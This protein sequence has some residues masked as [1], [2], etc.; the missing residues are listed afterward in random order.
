METQV[1]KPTCI[2]QAL[3]PQTGCLLVEILLA[4]ARLS[5]GASQSLSPRERLAQV[6]LKGN[7][8]PQGHMVSHSLNVQTR[9]ICFVFCFWSFFILCTICYSTTCISKRWQ[10]KQQYQINRPMIPSQ[11]QPIHKYFWRQFQRF[12]ILLSSISFHISNFT[13]VI[14]NI[15]CNRSVQ[16]R[17]QTNNQENYAGWQSNIV[18]QY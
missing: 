5:S 3:S 16:S 17:L 2:T 6:E 9:E 8:K 18:F 11:L 1:D 12:S 4:R 15:H 7:P 10:R 14:E 13:L